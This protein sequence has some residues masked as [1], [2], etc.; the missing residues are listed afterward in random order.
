MCSSGPSPQRALPAQHVG[1][2]AAAWAGTSGAGHSSSR[3]LAILLESTRVAADDDAGGGDRG[4]DGGGAATPERARIMSRARARVRSSIREREA[5]PSELPPPLP[6]ARPAPMAARPIAA[7]NAMGEQ[8]RTVAH[9][10]A[11]PPAPEPTHDML[12]SWRLHDFYEAAEVCER[13]C[14]I[15]VCVCVLRPRARAAV[16]RCATT[17]NAGVHVLRAA[18]NVCVRLDNA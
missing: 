9:L 2:L 10:H 16:G 3:S 1:G 5:L 12:L 7:L 15:L 6:L 8:V 14:V 13:A 4:G 18:A 11:V 17:R